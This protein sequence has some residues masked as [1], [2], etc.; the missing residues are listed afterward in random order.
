M[1]KMKRIKFYDDEIEF[2]KKHFKPDD[3][4]EAHIKNSKGEITVCVL[5]VDNTNWMKMSLAT[6]KMIHGD[7]CEIVLIQEGWYSRDTKSTIPLKERKDKRD[8]VFVFY[9]SKD[10]SLMHLMEFQTVNKK[11]KW[12]KDYSYTTSKNQKY[13]LNPFQFSK[14]EMDQL[15][16]LGKRD[17]MRQDGKLEERKLMKNFKMKIYTLKDEIFFEV[18]NAEGKAF[19]ISDPE[20]YTQEFYDKLGII[21]K[22][23]SGDKDALKKLSETMEKMMKE[24][25]V[26]QANKVG[27]AL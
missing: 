7:D 13:P 20:K 5:A 23:L 3:I 12:V 16:I 8:A 9:F 14:E 15:L 6:M 2:V 17:L 25:I 19:I 24:N 4:P 18:F 26:K 1:N 22:A 21:S 27:G 11:V 10:K